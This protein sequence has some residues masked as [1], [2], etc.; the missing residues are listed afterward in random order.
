MFAG[1]EVGEVWRVW[2]YRDSAASNFS[3]AH[4]LL[5]VL[6]ELGLFLLT[7]GSLRD[8]RS[9]RNRECEK[10]SENQGDGRFHGRDYLTT[11]PGWFP[12]RPSVPNRVLGAKME[13]CPSHL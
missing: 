11:L 5:A 8:Y 13:V 9:D 4:Q 7:D 1:K 6:D 10:D 2:R 3:L 12:P